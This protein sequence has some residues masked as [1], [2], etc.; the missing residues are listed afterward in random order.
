MFKDLKIIFGNIK[1]NMLRCIIGVVFV[2]VSTFLMNVSLSRFMYQEYLNSLVRD[3]G[4][5]KNYMYSAPPD[6]GVYYQNDNSTDLRADALHY[7]QD[8]LMELEDEGK[9]EAF[10]SAASFN[11]PITDDI[12]ERAY[13]LLYPKEFL[14]DIK[15]PTA[16]GEWFDK[17]DFNDNAIPVVI[18]CDLAAKYKIGCK[19]KFRGIDTEVRI[20][21]VLDKNAMVLRCG[22]GGNGIDLNSVFRK[23][24]DVIVACVDNMDFSNSSGATIIKVSEQYQQ[25]VLDCISDIVYT[26]SFKELSDT[27]Y[28]NN[29]LITEMQFVIFALMMI[30]C[31]TGVSSSNLL[32]TIRCKKKYAVY[33]M[34]GMDWKRCIRISFIESLFN[35]IIPT[36]IGY[37]AFLK[38]CEEQNFSALRITNTNVLVTTFFIIFVFVLTSLRPLI[39]IKNTSPVKIISET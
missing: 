32:E 29:R 25:N 18:G 27:A 21:G 5:Y 24:N 7:V 36:L 31:I 16:M 28:E 1:G 26:F 4:L 11:G 30:V 10:F 17:Y 35:L 19:Y 13:Y 23:G 2:G 33:F 9:I 15:F 22:A 6:K 38:W 12:D 20:I 39:D 3:C 37:I 8:N 14:C 34:C